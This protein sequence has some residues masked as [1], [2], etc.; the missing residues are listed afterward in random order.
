MSEKA[1]PY[2]L[3]LPGPT[4]VPEGIRVA[5]AHP[6]VAHR[7]P[8]FADVMT[9]MSSLAKTVFGTQNEVMA[10]ASS[11]T[12]LT[13][14]AI[15]NVLGPK[16]VGLILVDGQFGEKLV[17]IAQ[18]LNL[19]ADT[20]EVPWGESVAAD[21]VKDKLA[22]RNYRA[23]FAVHNESS[24][25]AVADLAAIGEA[26]RASDAL[27]VVDSVSGVGGLE[28]KQDA[29]GVDVVVTASQKALMCPPG[30]ALASVSDKAWSVIERD[31]GQA[32]FYWDLRRARE[33]AAKGQ[34]TFTSPIP[35]VYGMREALRMIHA[36]GWSNVLARHRRLSA[37]LRAGGEAL[38]LPAFARARALSP[39]VCVL[40]MPEG[41]DGS[42]VVRHL[43]REYG[44]VIA[45][46]RSKLQGKVIRIGTMGTISEADI[47]TDL[48]H[49]E[50]TLRDLE[51]KVEPGAG[52]AAVS[53]ALEAAA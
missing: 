8:E 51:W 28:L 33:A 41:L 14:A 42:A 39:T 37:A 30:L 7:G 38:G 21:S 46:S 44:T 31:C 16:D 48:D 18:A 24:T 10:F 22:T 3:R 47:L 26:V 40:A 9:E 45:G 2:R 53:A 23:V 6:V 13:E 50:K 36:E 25:G 52:E 29:W 15:A 43:Y 27:L 35:L 5:L 49:L 19:Q 12:G 4:A 34:T 11:G 1:P 20:L 32:R 17:Q